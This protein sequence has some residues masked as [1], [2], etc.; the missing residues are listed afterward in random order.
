MDKTVQGEV[1]GV[2]VYLVEIEK[3]ID[4]AEDIVD[5]KMFL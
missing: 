1:V 5:K 4:R 2:D 3:V